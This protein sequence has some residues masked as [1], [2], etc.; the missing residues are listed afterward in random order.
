[1]WHYFEQEADYSKALGEAIT[2]Q[3]RDLLAQKEQ[4]VLAVS[5]GK[6]PIPL[7]QFLSQQDLDWSRVVLQLVDERMLTRQHPDSNSLL[8]S[9]H[10]HQHLACKAI[11]QSDLP[12]SLD[13]AEREL[14]AAEREQVLQDALSSFKQPDVVIL[15]MGE[16]GHTAS[17]FPNAAQLQQGLAANAPTLLLVEP[18][19]A[20]YWRLSMGM[21]SILAVSQCYV[22]AFGAKKRAVLEQAQHTLSDDLPI[23]H[24]LHKKQGNTLHVYC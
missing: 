6:S 1:M 21:A 4:V 13:N 12:T 17:L 19:A 2:A 8:V 16:D 24:V 14:T 11:W 20:P 22:A 9:T 18:P 10:L 23:S 7:F 3:L 15:G 5:G